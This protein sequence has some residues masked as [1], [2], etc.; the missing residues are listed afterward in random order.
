VS[1]A[2]AGPQGNAVVPREKTLFA[3]VDDL[4]AFQESL[5]ML[6]AQLAEALPDEERAEIQQSRA[7]L[8]QR[9]DSIAAE[10]AVKSDDLAFVLRRMDHEYDYQD[11]EIDR[12]RTKRAAT[13]KARKWLRQYVVS[14]MLR[15]GL[16]QL[17]TPNN[18][19]FLRSSDA[20]I[21]TDQQ[22][23]DPVYQN[24]TVA[25]PLW[26]WNA[27]V[28]AAEGNR[29]AE[30]LPTLRVKAEPS[31]STIKKAIKSGVTVEGADLEL[32]ESLVCR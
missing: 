3:I 22:L 2:L 14:V 17:K 8:A 9:V 30:H 4:M 32:H 31:L 20:V 21:V 25:L 27:L 10:L 6:D 11:G 28:K 13:D 1:T 16:R 23:L 18:T 7:E 5:D 12:L 26:M 24:A 29:V 15:N 19:L